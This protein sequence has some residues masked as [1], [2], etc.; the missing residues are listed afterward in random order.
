V[1][2]I[3][4]DVMTEISANLEF[5]RRDENMWSTAWKVCA[6]NWRTSLLVAFMVMS[7]IVVK[8]WLEKDNIGGGV[9]DAIIWSTLAIASFRTLLLGS[10]GLGNERTS[11]YMTA[12]WIRSYALGVL[13]ILPATGIFLLLVIKF[14]VP[15]E[16]YLGIFS[17][18]TFGAIFGVLVFSLWGTWLP[19]VIADGDRTI[20]AAYRRGTKTFK[21]SLPRLVIGPGLLTI[22]VG[23]VALSSGRFLNTSDILNPP[24]SINFIPALFFTIVTLVNIYLT[25]LGCVVLARAY[26][27]AEGLKPPIERS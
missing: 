25:V 26:C 8:E 17:I 14:N 6:V 19:A 9:V 10:P 24:R 22:V 15:A 4:G 1:N 7:L 5:I 18:I 16:S 12:F 23:L 27:Q 3:G 13:Y 11:K 20:A 2:Q 21:F